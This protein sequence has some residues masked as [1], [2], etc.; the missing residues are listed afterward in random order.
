MVS[1]PTFDELIH[2]PARLRICGLLRHV[3]QIEFAVLRDILE[4]SDASLSKHL[5]TLQKAGYVSLTKNHSQTRTDARRLTWIQQTRIG[6]DAFDS[7]IRE[8]E[9]IT[10]A[11]P[12]THPTTTTEQA[13]NQE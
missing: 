8:L 2:A 4:I 11:T 5:K 3:D 9:R 1:D 12:E 7:H 6:R 13:E 10:T